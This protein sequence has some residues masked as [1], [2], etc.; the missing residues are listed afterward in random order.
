M[1]SWFLGS[2][3]AKVR[4]TRNDSE[5]GTSDAVQRCGLP[6]P[7]TVPVRKRVGEAGENP[8]PDFLQAR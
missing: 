2:G 5:N 1:G 3:P 8:Q 7:R 4:G 6:A